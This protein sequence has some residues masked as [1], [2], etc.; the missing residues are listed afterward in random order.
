[1]HL[2]SVTLIM[3]LVQGIADSFQDNQKM[4][5]DMSNL[6]ESSF[7]PHEDWSDFSH[8][9]TRE[10]TLIEP[11]PTPGIFSS[12]ASYASGDHTPYP[13]QSQ[14][15]ALPLLR[16]DD[17]NENCPYDEDLPTCIHY[18]IEWKVTLKSRVV[19]KDTEQDLVLN[20]M[21]HWKFFLNPKL[22]KLLD[23]KFPDRRVE[24]DDTSIAVSAND[25]SQRDLIKRFEE[26]NIDWHVVENQLTTWAELFRAGKKLRVK[27]TDCCGSYSYR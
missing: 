12:A 19:S 14:P 23:K 2:S 9:Q 11:A 7:N 5:Q 4:T 21:D 16:W 15:P 17:G 20:P 1:M 26:T 25:R 3:T 6:R 24:I 27:N 13:I 8:R 18:S 10:S 22:D